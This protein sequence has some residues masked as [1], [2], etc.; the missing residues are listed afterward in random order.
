MAYVP[1]EV[2]SVASLETLVT[3]LDERGRNSDSK[4][5]HACVASGCV[6]GL[7]FMIARTGAD[8]KA[9]PYLIVAAAK[10]GNLVMVKKLIDSGQAV[11]SEGRDMGFAV[12]GNNLP[13]I[14]LLMAHGGKCDFIQQPMNCSGL[15]LVATSETPDVRIAGLLIARKLDVNLN[16]VKGNTALMLAARNG[17]VKLCELLLDNGAK[18]NGN[19]RHPPLEIKSINDAGAQGKTMIAKCVSAPFDAS[20]ERVVALEQADNGSGSAESTAINSRQSK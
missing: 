20:F 9:T 12:I 5:I 7:D 2:F 17:H 18:F 13:L 10:S 15:H 6:E 14:E 11:D 16:D 1:V 19:R 8:L 4:L 3:L